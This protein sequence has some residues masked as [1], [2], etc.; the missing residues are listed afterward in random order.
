[1]KSSIALIVATVVLPGASVS[2]ETV[3][4]TG[5]PACDCSLVLDHVV[6]L[7]D[8]VGPGTLLG[9]VRTVRQG[10]NGD[11]FVLS[12]GA[13]EITRFDKSGRALDPVGREGE[14]PGEFKHVA[15]IWFVGDSIV[16]FDRGLGRLTV[17]RPDL[18]VARTAPL[19]GATRDIA[20]L[21]GQG[22]V[23]NGR[24]VGPRGIPLHLV[25]PEGEHVR[26]FGGEAI[27]RFAPPDAWIRSVAAVDGLVWAAPENS[28]R[29]E[30]W[31][32]DG[33]HLR[34]L[35]RVEAWFPPKV[36]RTWGG[37][38]QPIDPR[39]IDITSDAGGRLRVAI[40]KASR[41]WAVRLPAPLPNARGEPIHPVPPGTGL[42]ETRIEII[43]PST[44]RMIAFGTFEVEAFGFVDPEHVFTY[45]EDEIGNPTVSVWRLRLTR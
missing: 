6:D 14:G 10:P 40:L 16:V 5:E 37:P 36:V 28:Y 18:S 21:D 27:D 45:A 2:Q 17:L 32:A 35:E 25:T 3:Q 44:E 30:A 39:V 11:Y 42:F 9:M 19:A 13:A 38:D 33:R 24:F 1:M 22:F 43:D 4:I 29:L 31:T 26:S 8:A 12:W 15:G 20:W 34:T 23:L 7:G 41:H